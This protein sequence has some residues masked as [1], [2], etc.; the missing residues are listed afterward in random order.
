MSLG[1][2]ERL[3]NSSRKEMNKNIV[4]W[5]FISVNG[6][7]AYNKCNIGDVKWYYFD[8]QQNLIPY[9]KFWNSHKSKISQIFLEKKN[10]SF[11]DIHFTGSK[12]FFLRVRWKFIEHTQ[13]WKR[14]KNYS[15]NKEFYRN[16]WKFVKK[17]LVRNKKDKKNCFIVCPV[18]SFL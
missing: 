16:C 15:C 14:S 3:N 13:K 1:L 2:I 4:I 10:I 8:L 12:H 5:T 17:K 11:R 9:Q 7:E 18:T 6:Q